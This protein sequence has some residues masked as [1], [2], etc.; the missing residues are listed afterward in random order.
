MPDAA[1]PS[2]RRLLAEAGALIDWPRGLA[3]AEAIGR[4]RRAADPRP[5]LVIPGFM[6]NDTLT[7]PLRDAL[8]AAGHR[9]HGA[10]VGRITGPTPAL[11]AALEAR[12]AAIADAARRPVALVGWSL[13][14]LFARELA[15]RMP[16]RIERVVTLG[17]PFSGFPPATNVNW[18]YERV[19][20]TRV[21]TLPAGIAP[22]GEKPP[23]FTV[24]L[25]SRRDG[26][27]PPASSRGLPH[28]A[29][30]AR[31][32]DCRHTSFVMAPQ[33]LAAVLEALALERRG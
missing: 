22:P 28:E 10:E 33:A 4:C 14:G 8:A 1:A 21:A 9:P 2:L 26:I 19:N 3:G 27:V 23:V 12:T 31:E 7:R 32:V 20:D 15:R 13:G 24:A 11:V 25:W 16:D 5:V 17:S 29:D 18:L 30:V 6:A